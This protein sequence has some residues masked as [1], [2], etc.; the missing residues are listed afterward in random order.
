MFLT[1]SRGQREGVVPA[2]RMEKAIASKGGKYLVARTWQGTKFECLSLEGGRYW[3]YETSVVD[4]DISSSIGFV[5]AI[6]KQQRQMRQLFNLQRETSLTPQ[7]HR[8][9]RSRFSSP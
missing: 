7:S 3:E 4:F 6:E 9:K 5:V 8:S 1:L 2:M